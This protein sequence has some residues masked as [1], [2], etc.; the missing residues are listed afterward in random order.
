MLERKWYASSVTEIF[1]DFDVSL[2]VLVDVFLN[3]TQIPHTNSC[4]IGLG[5]LIPRAVV[6]NSTVELGRTSRRQRV[7]PSLCISGLPEPTLT[8]CCRRHIFCAR[9]THHRC[10]PPSRGWSRKPRQ[11][12]A[13]TAR[14]SGKPQT[15]RCLGDT[16]QVWCVP[17]CSHSPEQ[18][19]QATPYYIQHTCMYIGLEA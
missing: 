4:I 5:A 18:G 8:S 2:V 11:W 3:S 15:S 19:R 10:D 13:G 14:V 1:R 12:T 9:Q 17:S 6:Q 16:L 7:D